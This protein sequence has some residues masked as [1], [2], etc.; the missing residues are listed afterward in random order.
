MRLT[1]RLL[2]IASAT[3]TIVNNIYFHQKQEIF[4]AH[5]VIH[6]TLDFN[7]Q[8]I[9]DHC[10]EFRKALRTVAP[11]FDGGYLSAVWHSAAD[12]VRAT[13][14]FD[15]VWPGESLRSRNN[16]PIR[17]KRQLMGGLAV[18]GTLFGLYNWGTIHALSEEVKAL[19][20]HVRTDVLIIAHHETRMA[21]LE[22]D[23]KG[24]N[25]TI[26]GL[27]RAFNKEQKE[28][29]KALWLQNLQL[30]FDVLRTHVDAAR[31]GWIALHAQRLPMEWLAGPRVEEVFQRI[32]ARAQKMGG[33]LPIQH[34]M[35]LFDLPTSFA[36]DNS[37]ARVFVH[38]PV[39]KE[40]MNLYEFLPVPIQIREQFVRLKPRKNMIMVGKANRIHQEI[41]GTEL[42]D[43]CHQLGAYY[44]C[45]NLGVFIKDMRTTC[46]GTLFSNELTH[47]DK[48]CDVEEVKED[49]DVTQITSH[50]FLVYVRAPT[51]LMTECRNGTRTNRLLTNLQQVGVDETCLTYTAQVELRTSTVT[52]VR[53]TMVQRVDWEKTSLVALWERMQSPD[54]TVDIRVLGNLTLAARD[55]EDQL[56]L[57]EE[58]GWLDRQLQ[59]H[60][61]GWPLVMMC[62]ILLGVAIGVLSYL[63][64]R[65]QH[66]RQA[67]P[68]T[69]DA[70]TA[71]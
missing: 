43:K 46:L 24:L 10:D 71:S 4:N 38:L 70:A 6:V 20:A 67:A 40:P 52:A 44:M 9:L 50:S 64:W 22:M 29:M 58:A 66:L 7:F 62:V 33:V 68:T 18:F 49:W 60:S 55:E 21:R 3:G 5:E 36:W 39:I 54:Q 30:Q 16:T 23:M 48:I 25:S 69:G 26:G 27:M 53:L 34:R 65:Y 19:T 11:G 47:I 59:G 31:Q 2:L 17:E 37:I 13:C 1:L 8:P 28:H 41:S 42:R 61:L 15:H 45:E 32:C 51:N 12:A 14:D 56:R 63:A 57:R 35:D